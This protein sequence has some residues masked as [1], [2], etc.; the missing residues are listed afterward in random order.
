MSMRAISS[1]I[2]YS[3]IWAGYYGIKRGVLVTANNGQFW[4]MHVENKFIAWLNFTLKLNYIWTSLWT[5]FKLIALAFYRD[6]S[7]EI[8]WHFFNKTRCNWYLSK[9]VKCRLSFSVRKFSL[10]KPYQSMKTQTYTLSWNIIH[11]G[12]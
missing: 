2:I 5:F 10:S 12:T 3:W 1:C 4:G 6:Y 7:C 9:F 11:H 8:G